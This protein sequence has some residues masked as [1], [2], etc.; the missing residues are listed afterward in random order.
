MC[1]GEVSDRHENHRLARMREPT[2]KALQILLQVDSRSAGVLLWRLVG[3]LPE[4]AIRRVS[5]KESPALEFRRLA[6][7][8]VEEHTR[9]MMCVCVTVFVS[10]DSYWCYVMLN[11]A[12]A[13]VRTGRGR[14][15][16]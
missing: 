15:A 13:R 4:P 14:M 7:Q 16:D 3:E 11:C 8:E 1:A 6:Q 10:V 2:V 5:Y 12:T 9:S